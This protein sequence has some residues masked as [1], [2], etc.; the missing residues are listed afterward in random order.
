MEYVRGGLPED[1]LLFDLL[2]LP[3]GRDPSGAMVRG[4]GAWQAGRL[5]GVALSH[6]TVLLDSRM[7]PEVLE[8]LCG[9]LET[10]QG[11][12]LKSAEGPVAML[13]DRLAAC[14][15]RLT[16]DR[17]ETGLLLRPGESKG[18]SSPPGPTLRA[19]RRE[20]LDALVGIAR[21][22]LREEGRPDPGDFDP[23]GFR[24]WVDSRL[25]RA[26]ILDVDGEVAWA[27][28]ADV[29]RREGWL[30]QGVYTRPPLRGRGL[31]RA[32]MAGLIAEARAAGADHVQLTVVDG[33]DAAH[34]L[35][36]GLGFEPYGRVRTLVF[37]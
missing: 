20:D 30:I 37:A 27:G 23:R 33:N 1:L 6:P 4:M 31:A 14:G 36:R 7:A 25:S 11:G 2:G 19:A 22:S 32:G 17:M 10:L 3:A 34:R 24:R 18:T 15:R 16:L 8:A 9:Q 29:R 35:Y 13:W 5:V 12:L 28:Y 21:A 26:R